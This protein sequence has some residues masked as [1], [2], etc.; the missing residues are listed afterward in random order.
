MKIY[1][2]NYDN[3]KDYE[4][5]MVYTIGLEETYDAAYLRGWKYWSEN[6][7]DNY[8]GWEIKVFEVGGSTEAI[9]EHS[10]AFVDG[11]IKKWVDWNEGWVPLK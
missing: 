9:E 11:T 5:H 2:V 7:R 6:G 10:Y 1:V 8:A 3:G 4:S